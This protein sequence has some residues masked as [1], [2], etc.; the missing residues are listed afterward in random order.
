MRL[1]SYR[2]SPAADEKIEVGA[3]IGLLNMLYI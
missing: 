1:P 2:M 3:A